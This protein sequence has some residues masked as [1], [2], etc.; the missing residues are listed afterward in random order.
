MPEALGREIASERR[1]ALVTP[2]TLQSSVHG[3]YVE[4]LLPGETV[5]PEKLR[6]MVTCM[7]LQDEAYPLLL[8]DA[9]E[10]YP[11]ASPY[12]NIGVT[13]EENAQQYLCSDLWRGLLASGKVPSRG[14]AGVLARREIFEACNGL[15]DDFAEGRPRVFF[16][17]RDLLS[18]AEKLPCRLLC[19][20]HETYAGEAR[21][22]SREELAAHQMD[23]QEL[24]AEDQ[25]FLEEGARAD[26]ADRQRRIGISLL[27][28]ALAAKEDLQAGIW[29]A[30]QEMLLR[31]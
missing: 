29:P 6:R 30:Y 8:S 27:E 7:E 17:W 2:E 16:M 18:A 28:Q 5:L 20:L 10:S 19:V 3:R 9:R 26:I 25:T 13:P 31:L 15:L 4:W 23:W 11:E 22:L 21:L 14:L 1:C 12:I 24:C